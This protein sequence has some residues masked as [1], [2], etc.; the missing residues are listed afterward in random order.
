MKFVTLRNSKR[1]QPRGARAFRLS[2]AHK[3]IRVTV[4]V[5]SASSPQARRNAIEKL[6]TQLPRNRRYLSLEEFTELH[7]ARDED[8]AVVKQF[9]KKNHLHV[10]EISKP[11]RCVVLS[12]TIL[13]FSRAFQVH[14]KDFEHTGQ[15]YRSHS[16]AIQIPADLADVIEGILGLE[17]RPLM[18]HHTFIAAMHSTNHVE[19]IEVARAYQFPAHVNGEGERIAI[20]ELGGGFNDQDIKDYFQKHGFRTPRI[21]VHEIDGQKNSPA[22]KQSVEQVLKLMGVEKNCKTNA[23]MDQSELARAMWT[24]EST[25]DIQLAGSFANGGFIDVY[26][27]PN[28]AQGKY[29]ALTSVLTNKECAPTILSCSWGAAEEELPT[30]VVH[31]LNQIFQDAAL[32]G[33]TV[34][35]SSGDKGDDQ[36]KDGKPRAHYP[37]TSPHV[38]SCGGTH[39]N[40]SGDRL[41]EVVWNETLPAGVVKS[42]GGVSHIFEMP[43][44]QSSAKV[45]SKTNHKGRGTPDVSGKADIQRGYCT[46]VVGFK[47]TMGGT[48]SAAPMWAGLIARINEK[49]GC[50]VGFLTP[51]LYQKQFAQTF[52]DITRGN[53]GKF[54]ASRGWDPC[55]GWGTPNGKKLLKILSSGS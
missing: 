35:F 16:D 6:A 38:L 55:T 40:L 31:I 49:L 8:L 13:K 48:S 54:K 41:S 46:L 44:W 23:K 12:G 37:A 7:G 9:A 36:G 19:P 50:R 20:I 22:T 21:R 3:K 47:I 18:T 5:R 15:T 26:F 2:N 11:R 14:L 52:N 51:L 10:V 30:D 45:K 17:D 33:I 29:H 53:N 43:E 4:V 42:G 28:N 25:I 27:A 34:C 1:Q 24:I 32:L 39:W